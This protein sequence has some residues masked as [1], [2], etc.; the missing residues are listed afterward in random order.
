MENWYKKWFDKKYLQLYRHRGWLDAAEQVDLILATLPLENSSPILDLA[1]GDG[2]HCQLLAEKGYRVFGLDLSADLLQQA[3]KRFSRL[4]LIRADMREI[5]GVFTAILSLFTSFGYFPR[6]CENEQVMAEISLSLLPGGWFWLDF[7]NPDYVCRHIE[8]VTEKK[9]CDHTRVKETR[10]ICDKRIIKEIEF[11]EGN[12]VSSYLESV[13][14]YGK[15]ELEMM[16]K[17]NN[18]KPI[19]AFGDYCG[20]PWQPDS[21]RTIIYGRKHS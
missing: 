7:L 5:P 8:P 15:E 17:K 18:I 19:G 9:L 14:L 4:N 13:C 6:Y 11:S 3:K 2:R 1:C 10:Y 16:M 12:Q 20:N 21:P